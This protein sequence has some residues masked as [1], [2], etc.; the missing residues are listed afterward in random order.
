M[1]CYKPHLLLWYWEFQKCMSVNP[2]CLIVFTHSP[3]ASLVAC[4]AWWFW[5]GTQSNKGRRGRRNRKE[6][7]AGATR[8][9]LLGQVAFFNSPHAC[10]EIVPIGSECWSL[11]QIFGNLRWESSKWL[12]NLL[13]KT[14][15]KYQRNIDPNVDDL[16]Y[17]TGKQGNCIEAWTG[18]GHLQ[19]SS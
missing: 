18:N 3:I 13:C 7:G 14:K 12:K 1:Y 11:N 6:F 4:V 9:R 15:S 2:L 8:N 5:L 16:E 10:V 19:P 17:S